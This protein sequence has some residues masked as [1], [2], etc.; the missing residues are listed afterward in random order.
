MLEIHAA[1]TLPRRKTL[2]LGIASVLLVLPM[3]AMAMLHPGIALTRVFGDGG[4]IGTILGSL[5]FFFAYVS[6]TQKEAIGMLRIEN[7]SLVHDGVP[8]AKLRD[9]RE[10]HAWKAEDGA[11]VQLGKKLH[12]R[13]ARIEDARALLEATGVDASRKAARFHIIAPSRL[14]HRAR[15]GILIA[16]LPLSVALAILLQKMT[17]HPAPGPIYMLPYLLAITAFAIPGSVQIGVDGVLVRW[18]WQQRFIPLSEI[19][20]V[21]TTER[22][23]LNRTVLGIR[24]TLVSGE[25]LDLSVASP[26]S[27]TSDASRASVQTIV[28]RIEEAR[29]VARGAGGADAARVLGRDGRSASDWLAALRQAFGHVEGFRGGPPLTLEQLWR[30]VEDPDARPW[31]R[32]AAAAALAH[33][34]DEEKRT[35]L[36]VVAEATAAPKLR[37]ALE[38]AAE[39]NDEKIAEAL[40]SFEDDQPPGI[41]KSI[42]A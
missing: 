23:F 1:R 9:L 20:D 16:S 27:R 10:G 32:A 31:V 33:D 28:E 15:L 35:R 11:H 30:A 34:V 24:L 17:G 5:G 38:A 14:N 7:G 26:P 41:E 6:Q 19:S 4:L 13:M 29:E 3:I 37:I 42:S 22:S 18:L 25:T 36:R 2:A 40:E 39:A 12:L 21:V 8:I